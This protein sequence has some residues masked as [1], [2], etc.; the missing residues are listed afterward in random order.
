LPASAIEVKDYLDQKRTAVQPGAA[1]N[2][3]IFNPKLVDNASSKFLEWEFEDGISIVLDSSETKQH[4][5]AILAQNAIAFDRSV[6]L[7]KPI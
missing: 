3:P 4:G 7:R 5:P 2:D 6:D 1:G